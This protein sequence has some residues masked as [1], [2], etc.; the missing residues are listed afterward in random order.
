LVYIILLSLDNRNIFLSILILWK[1]R[2]KREKFRKEKPQKIKIL[3]VKVIISPYIR[4]KN[5]KV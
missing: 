2:G 1:N 3:L 4:K 5:R